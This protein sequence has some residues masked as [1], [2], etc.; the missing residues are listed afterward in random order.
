MTPL[1]LVGKI[2]AIFDQLGVPWVLG[3]S[4]A[5]SLVG[6]PRSTLDIDMAVQL[7]HDHAEALLAAVGDDFYA[8]ADMIRSAV[9]ASRSFNLLHYE[10]AMKVDVFVLGS[11]LLDRRQMER[12]TRVRLSEPPHLELWAT[13]PDDLVLRKLAWF[14][15]GGEVSDRQWRDVLGIL[16]VQ[17][18]RIDHVELLATADQ[19]GLGQLC[20]RAI[21]E[22]GR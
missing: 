20:R 17:G 22:T 3:G 1:E 4:V 12:R 8:S 13:A 9:A 19:L 16:T 5:G 15:L 10:S 21:A 18:D 14:R 11:G 7:D 2:G 6:E